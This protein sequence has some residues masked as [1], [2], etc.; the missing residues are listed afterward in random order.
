MLAEEP[1]VNRNQTVE[2]GVTSMAYSGNEPHLFSRG[3]FFLIGRG[4]IRALSRM[5]FHLRVAGEENLPSTKAVILAPNHNSYLDAPLLAAASRRPLRFLADAALFRFRATAG[6]LRASGALPVDRAQPDTRAVRMALGAIRR[7]EVVVIVPEGG[8]H[9]AQGPIRAQAGVAALASLSGAP[10]V[11]VGINGSHAAWPPGQR[12]PRPKPI[13]I[14]F[15]S[16]MSF[17]KAGVDRDA[18]CELREA[19]TR[20]LEERICALRDS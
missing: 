8:R 1:G 3:P 14:T 16:A 5:A 12:L 6:L 20:A 2:G 15:G 13:K 19:F 18:S 11:P 4:L 9:N 10:V 17:P 7:N